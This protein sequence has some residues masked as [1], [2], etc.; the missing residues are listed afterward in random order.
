MKSKYNFL[1]MLIFISSIAYTASVCAQDSA[2]TGK[3]FSFSVNP[4]LWAMTLSGK[5]AL[6]TRFPM[7][8]QTPVVDMNLKF[9]DAIEHLKM[10]AMLTG[11]FSYKRFSLIYD[12]DYAKLGYDRV[13]TIKLDK[14]VSADLSAKTFNGDFE[15]GYRLPVQDKKLSVDVYAGTRITSLNN[16]LTF[17]G[18]RDSISTFSSSK[19]W[20]DP[21]VGVYAGCDFSKKWFAYLKG[22]V[23]GFGVSSKFTWLLM[24]VG[25]YRFSYHWNT[26]LGFKWLGT[27]Y[28]K[29]YYLWNASQYG[30]VLSFGYQL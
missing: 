27:N 9:S 15:I 1:A 26:T 13:D 30:V 22:D 24:G 14:Y 28:D 2:K 21:I 8:P 23:G 18:I 3:N 7:K 20:V 25:G 4:Y 17:H 10:A 5:S 16:T 6:P 19:T 12:V 11:R 29:D